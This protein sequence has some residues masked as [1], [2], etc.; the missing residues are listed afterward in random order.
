VNNV[1]LPFIAVIWI[2]RDPLVTLA[3]LFPLPLF[4][5]SVLISFSC[6]PEIK[7]PEVRLHVLQSKTAAQFAAPPPSK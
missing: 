5:L 4:S 1:V 6:N 2:F 3:I 7:Q